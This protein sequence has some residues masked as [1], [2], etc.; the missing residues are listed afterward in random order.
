MSW[1]LRTAAPPSQPALDDW[2][3]AL[4]S[5]D[6]DRALQLEQG[7]MPSA[8]RERLHSQPA[9]A[10]QDAGVAV[11]LGRVQALQRHARQ[12]IEQVEGT[13]A[14]IS[15]RSSEQL[16]FLAKTRDNLGSSSSGAEQLRTEMDLELRATQTFF[17]TEFAEL[18]NSLD[19]RSQ[20]SRQVIDAI[21]HIGRTVQLLSINAAIEAAHAGEQGRGFAVVAQE[22]RELALSTQ[23]NAQQAYSQIDLAPVSEQLQGMLQ[24]ADARLE[25]LGQRVN[26]SLQTLHRQLDHMADHLNE[27]EANNKVMAAGVA[28]GEAADQHLLARNNWSLDLLHDMHSI[29][30]ELPNQ[31]RPQAV[32]KLLA[33]EKLHTHP[34]SDRLDAIRQR[35]EL[36]IAIEPHFKGL[37]FRQQTG[38]PLQGMDA[39]LARAF[40]RWLGVK[41]HFVEY[42][43]DRCLQL[44]EAGSRRREAEVDVVWSALPPMPDYGQVAFSD[45]YVFLPYVLAKRA[46]DSRIQRLDDLQGKVLGCIDDPAALEVLEQAGLRW[47]SN[48]HTPGGRIELANLLAYNDQS[49]IHDCLADGTVDAFAVDLPIY[50]W[51]CTG[52]DSPWAGQLEILPGNLSSELWF[53]CAA[54]ANQPGNTALLRAIN[55]FIAEFRTTR[56]YQQLVERWQGQVYSANR[57]QFQPGVHDLKS[58]EAGD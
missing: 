3:Q 48:R 50:H 15:A 36:R 44:L 6:W 31:Q 49:L 2:Q 29:Y 55:Q 26:E 21:D 19:E 47:E 43:W 5:G 54:V 20:S 8:L 30:R 45:P 16:T 34:R 53:Y 1:F 14:E 10:E 27:I 24:D 40:A 38:E 57:W 32:Q 4:L 41:C 18:A 46:G 37:S 56:D 22:I 23:A 7:R 28:L 9:N 25:L 58:L 52:T 12:A 42:P 51:A 11:L 39:E 33:E 17:S 35:G 13:F